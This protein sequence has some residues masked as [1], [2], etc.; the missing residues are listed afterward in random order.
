MLDELIVR[1]LGVITDA[2]VEP[3]SGLVVVSGET[4]AGKTML[5]GALE[6]L[7]GLAARSSVVG[8]DGDEAVVEGRFVAE[9]G[10][11]VVVSRRVR[12]EGRS[13][14]YLN[15][16]MA[17]LKEVTDAMVGLVEIVSQHDH[18][19]LGKER[20]VRALIDRALTKKGL[21]AKQAYE[22]AWDAYSQLVAT[23]SELGS[24]PG[25]LERERD[26]AVWQADEITQAAFVDGDD[27]TL[28]ER[29]NRLRNAEELTDLLAA[30]HGAS[31]SARDYWGEVVGAVRNAMAMDATLSPIVADI[32]AVAEQV[33]EAVTAIRSAGEQITSDP[34][35]L[36]LAEER[37]R[38]LSDL[39]RKYGPSLAE[40]LAFGES[41][42]LRAHEI[43]SRMAQA[44]SMS[45]DLERSRSALTTAG[46]VLMEERV[47]AGER[48]GA[49]AVEHLKELGFS[50]PILQ[51]EVAASEP[52]AA[53]CDKVTISF[54]SDARLAPGPVT[55]VASGGELSR[56]VLALRLAG[57]VGE[58]PVI[59]FDEID[60]G[61]GGRTA[62]ELGRK[63]AELARDKQVL[64]VTHLPQVAAFADTHL[65]VERD[66]A[67]ASVVR[68]SESDQIDELARM[69]AGLDDSPQGREHALELRRTA[70]AQLSRH[71]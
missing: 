33:A 62:L 37:M 41:A 44:H 7:S 27:V 51:C 61:V 58:A 64:V 24:D 13:R 8:P 35:E 36:E 43:D 31:V 53:G 30:G 55:R 26:L 47:A 9:D 49:Q 1:N 60:A 63:L 10:S 52:R 57:G 48:L 59:A 5:L 66:G 12:T 50:D 65:L 18:L 45:A 46:S 32:E 42:S 23:A 20:E 16:G 25:A 68:L 15:G 6:L 54:A 29:A 71:S 28:S 19:A 21:E 17:T 40:V 34:A 11:E 56:L 3:G 70:L 4:G 38:L 67:Q 2:R 39:R 14:A 69:L 22:L